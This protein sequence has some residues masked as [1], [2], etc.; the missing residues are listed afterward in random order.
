MARRVVVELTDVYKVY[1]TGRIEYPALK[2]VNLRVEEGE[3][4][5]IVGPSGS[6]KTTLLNLVGGIDTPTRDTVRVLGTE[7]SRKS[8]G[9]R[10]K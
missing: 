2:G 7:I 1:R 10:A 5:A 9:W 3:F 4:L 6:G 8:E